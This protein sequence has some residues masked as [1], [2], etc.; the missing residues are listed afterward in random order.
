MK[1]QIL[2]AKFQIIIKSQ[3]QNL[4]S[5]DFGHWNLFGDC[6]LEF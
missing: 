4:N 2:S 6:N 5:L 1:S 3:I